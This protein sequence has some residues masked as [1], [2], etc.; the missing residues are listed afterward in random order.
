MKL[1]KSDALLVYTLLFNQSSLGRSF[2]DQLD[3]VLDRIFAYLTDGD[4]GYEDEEALTSEESEETE[5]EDETESETED[6]EESVQV[7]DYVPVSVLEDL[8]SASVTSPAGDEM[9]LEFEKSPTNSSSVDALL[10]NGTVII[11]GISVV[12]L[13]EKSIEL[14]DGS[15]WHV[16]GCKRVPKQWRKTFEPSVSYGIE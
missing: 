16:F 7:D 10:D 9:T 12:K 14:H 4:S 2:D 13:T 3:D 15:E 1:S 8:S 6:E 5:E 11:E